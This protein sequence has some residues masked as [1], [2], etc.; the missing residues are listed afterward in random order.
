MKLIVYIATSLD[1]FIAAEDGNV[2]WLNAYSGPEDEDYDKPE[3]GFF[4]FMESVDAVLMGRKTFE[5]VLGFGEWWYTKPVFVLSSN[6]KSIPSEYADK[7]ELVSGKIETVLARLEE[8]DFQSLY[9]D[10]GLL[11]QSLLE[12]DLVDDM[13]ITRIPILLGNGIPLFSDVP[14]YQ[15]FELIHTEEFPNSMIMSHYRRLRSTAS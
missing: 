14:A 9:V 15:H 8:R 3:Y 11:I 5:T 10:G 4:G 7:A 1:N 13:I 2:D 6:M 12:K